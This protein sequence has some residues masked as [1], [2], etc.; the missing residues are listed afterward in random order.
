MTQKSASVNLA[1]QISLEGSSVEDVRWW[2][3]IIGGWL[4][5]ALVA[6]ANTRVIYRLWLPGGRLWKIGCYGSGEVKNWCFDG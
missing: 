6:R 5:G 4:G 1:H 3:S 2:R